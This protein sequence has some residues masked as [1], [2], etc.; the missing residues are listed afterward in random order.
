MSAR[1]TLQITVRTL[2]T[3]SCHLV[4]LLFS[5]LILFSEYL[6]LSLF[7]LKGILSLLFYPSLRIFMFM[8]VEDPS[9]HGYVD[10]SLTIRL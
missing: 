8:S 1:C 2:S 4:C 7:I 9:L 6:G 10:G 5:L 3:A